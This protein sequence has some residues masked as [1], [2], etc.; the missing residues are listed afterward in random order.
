MSSLQDDQ[1]VVEILN[2]FYPKNTITVH[3]IN[4]ELKD[5]AAKMYAEALES[6]QVMHLV[7]RPSYTPSFNWL[8]KEGVKAVWRSRGGNDIYDSV[9]VTVARNFKTEYAMDKMGI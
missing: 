5:L 9:R 3:T 4:D 6:S 1:M 2:F 7:P 8:F